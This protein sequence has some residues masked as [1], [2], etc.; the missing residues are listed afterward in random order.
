MNFLTFTNYLLWV[1]LIIIAKITTPGKEHARFPVP[2]PPVWRKVL[3]ASSLLFW[4]RG[5]Q[6]R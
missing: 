5:K 1:G 3:Q 4:G 6:A 2:G